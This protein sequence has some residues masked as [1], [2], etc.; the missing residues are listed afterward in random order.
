MTPQSS[1][2]R[3]AD[4]SLILLYLTLTHI[5]ELTHSPGNDA[6]PDHLSIGARSEYRIAILIGRNDVWTIRSPQFNVTLSE[7]SVNATVPGVFTSSKSTGAV[8]RKLSLLN[9][10]NEL[11]TPFRVIGCTER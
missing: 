4:A 10:L 5:P 3:R 6:C 9:G 11:T 1:H 8:V 2:R 7:R